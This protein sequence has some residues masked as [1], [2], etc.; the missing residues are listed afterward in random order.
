MKKNILS[1][2]VFFLIG[3]LADAQDLDVSKWIQ[4]VDISARFRLDSFMVWC[5]SAGRNLAPG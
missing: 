3:F 2:L 5:G 1:T 4:P